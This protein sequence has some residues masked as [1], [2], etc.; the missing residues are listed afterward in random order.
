MAEL[1]GIE[2]DLSLPLGKATPLVAV[3]MTGLLLL[4]FL[5]FYCLHGLEG[6][7]D[8]EALQW[9]TLGFLPVFTLGVML[10]EL[11]HG[12]CFCLFGKVPFTR[13]RFGFDDKTLT[14]YTHCP[15]PLP[16]KTYKLSLVMPGL[17]LG[18]IPTLL[19]FNNGNIYWL[20]FGAVF[21]AAASGDFMVIWLIRKVNGDARVRDHPENPGC[22]LLKD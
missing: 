7:I 4:I 20:S 15:A 22:Y 13:I 21:T 3:L 14:P 18:A 12:M 16:A 5:I 1:S 11:I 19:A 8:S 2:K 17:V 6:F 9:L 10:H